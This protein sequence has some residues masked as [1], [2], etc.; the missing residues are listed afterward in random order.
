MERMRRSSNP[1]FTHLTPQPAAG[2]NAYGQTGWYQPGATTTAGPIAYAGERADRM[3]VEDVV[4]K[5]VI[6]LGIL[7]LAGAASWLLVPDQYAGITMIGALLIALVIG[8]IIGFGR[9]TNPALIMTYS[10]FEGAALGLI[11]SF[12]ES[13]PGW[14][15]IVVQAAIATFTIFGVMALLYTNRVIRATP[16]FRKMVMGALI[17]AVAVM[18]INLLLS[19][20]GVYTGLRGDAQGNGGALAIGFSLVMIGIG[21]MTFVLDFDEVERGVAAGLPRR[22]S[23]YCAFGIMLGLIWVYL[24]VLRLLSYLRGRD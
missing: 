3:T 13:Q 20:F 5:S 1:V 4:V 19:F 7:G 10:V 11:S 18:L 22:T 16:R 21:A 14:G 8:L 6:L 17:G 23:W 2:T 12:Y 15:G 24:E 9:S